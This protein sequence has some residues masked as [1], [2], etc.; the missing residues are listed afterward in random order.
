LS[1][2]PKGLFGIAQHVQEFVLFL[3]MLVIT[4]LVFVQV[5]LRYVFKAPLMGIE[6][7][8]LFPTV[9]LYMIGAA[10]ASIQRTQIVCRVLEV[11]VKNRL[12][13]I[14]LIRTA[15]SFL[16]FGVALWL[17]YWAYDY[18]KYALRVPRVSS[19]LYI[20][21]IYA[22]IALFIAMILITLYTLVEGFYNLGQFR[23]APAYV[24]DAPMELEP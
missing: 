18:L 6:E 11:F 13:S 4:V 24:E 3:L 5:L 10:N 2:Q 22:E 1:D 20:P 9:W 7:M 23:K 15:A 21:L 16:S 8:L 19:S 14:Y 12:K 17:D